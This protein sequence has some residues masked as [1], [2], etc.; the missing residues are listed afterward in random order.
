MWL[1]GTIRDI[2]TLVVVGGGILLNRDNVLSSPNNLVSRGMV[3][4]VAGLGAFLFKVGDRFVFPKHVH[5][6]GRV[7]V[8]RGL[9]LRSTAS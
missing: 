9:Y 4:I 8:N 1:R 2:E 3:G 7:S 6:G 5:V